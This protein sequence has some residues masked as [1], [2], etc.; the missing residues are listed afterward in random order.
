MHQNEFQ[1]TAEQHLGMGM[2]AE[3]RN[4]QNTG[5]KHAFQE[6]QKAPEQALQSPGTTTEQN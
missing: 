6:R 5:E 1:R 2:Q 4:R 3:N